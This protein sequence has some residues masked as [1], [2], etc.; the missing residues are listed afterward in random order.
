[1]K[2]VLTWWERPGG[3]HADYEAAMDA[4]AAEVEAI[5]WRGATF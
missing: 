2:Y 1:M 5:N 4:V 3:S